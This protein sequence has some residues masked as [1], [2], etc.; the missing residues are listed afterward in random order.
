MRIHAYYVCVRGH[1][2]VPPHVQGTGLNAP[3]TLI[4]VKA[5]TFQVVEG[6]MY[7]LTL[8]IKVGDASAP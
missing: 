7:T 8:S 2:H 5:A 4:Q 3:L 1:V 6:A